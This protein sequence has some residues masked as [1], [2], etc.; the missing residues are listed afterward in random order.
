MFG[1]GN[2]HASRCMSVPTNQGAADTEASILS[3]GSSRIDSLKPGTI[4]IPTNKNII[5]TTKTFLKIQFCMF[6]SSSPE[7][8]GWKLV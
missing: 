5:P 3:S 7:N 1:S 6:P 2:R 8:S 4:L